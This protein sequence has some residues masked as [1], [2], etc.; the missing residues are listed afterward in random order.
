M[1][2]AFLSNK[3]KQIK[4]RLLI[5]DDN[6]IRY[7][8][9]V[10]LLTSKGHQVDAFLLDDIKSF[11]KQLHTHWDVVLFGRAYD[12]KFEQAL[13]LIHASNQ[14]QLPL[15]LLNPEDYQPSQY[16]NYI[17]KGVYDL[18]NLDYPDRF[19]IGLVRTLSYSRS[20]QA[21]Q[22]L[23]KELEIAETHI[24]THAQD[25]HKAV[26]VIQEGIHIKANPEY[27]ALFGFKKKRKFSDYR[28][29]M[30]YNLNNSKILNSVL[31]VLRSAI[32]I[33]HVL[34]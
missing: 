29:L 19:Y 5:I 22:H 8:Q 11:E 28:C 31:N 9:I 20:L 24:Q 13:A 1:R 14:P 32:S 2:N 26:A 6:Q 15:L 17:N 10:D 27:L 25:T 33:R 34:K 21:Q 16:L 12:L 18:F 7:N 30:C 4:T 3:L 23:L